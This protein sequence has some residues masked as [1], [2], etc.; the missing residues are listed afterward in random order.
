MPASA[1]FVLENAP[2]EDNR[3]LE[4]FQV[5]LEMVERNAG[6]LLFPQLN[7]G[8]AAPLCLK[9]SCQLPSPEFY[10]KAKTAAAKA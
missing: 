1:A 7:R 8:Q 2:I 5:P 9:T 10:K 3:P 6:L 4:S